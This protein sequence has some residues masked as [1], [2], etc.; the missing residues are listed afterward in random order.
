[1]GKSAMTLIEDLAAAALAGD[2]LTARSLLQDFQRARPRLADV[3]PPSSRDPRVRSLAAALVE[4]MA[5]RNGE[6]PPRW[7]ADIGPV[8]EPIHLLKS[9]DRMSRL[10]HLCEEQS[11]E[12]LRRRRFFAPPNYLQSV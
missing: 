11:P 9:A 4:M 10:R 5:E 7:T 1:M 2:G 3:P 12:P 8:A 6:P